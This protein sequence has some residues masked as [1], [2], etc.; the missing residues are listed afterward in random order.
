MVLLPFL[1]Y[2]RQEDI[3]ETMEAVREILTELKLPLVMTDVTRWMR[4]YYERVPNLEL[5]VIDDRDLQD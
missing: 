4:P 3:N 1:G 2:Y 5:E